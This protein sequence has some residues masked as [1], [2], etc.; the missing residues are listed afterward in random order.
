MTPEKSNTQRTD[1]DETANVAPLACPF[2]GGQNICPSAWDIQCSDCSASIPGDPLVAIEAWNRRAAPTL[3][4]D[5]KGM[6]DEW[7]KAMEGVTPGPW[8]TEQMQGLR[9]QRLY[10]VGPSEIVHPH[11]GICEPARLNDRSFKEDDA[12]MRFIARCS[13]ENI[14]VL[15][16]AITSQSALLEAFLSA[17]NDGPGLIDCID[18][19]GDRYTSQFLCDTIRAAS[20]LIADMEG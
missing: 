15:L 8:S 6:A 16:S 17:H 1:S 3:P 9:V 7:R 19:E 20:R 14:E 4:T 5:V 2:C 11:D 12:N 13:P 10:V 18:N